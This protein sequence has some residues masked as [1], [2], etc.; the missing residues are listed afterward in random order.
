MVRSLQN[1]IVQSVQQGAWRKVKRLI[2]LLIRSFSARALAVKRV[3][4]NKGKKTAGIDG[5]RWLTPDQK[6]QAIGTIAR[7]QG[8]QPKALKRIR[9]PKKDKSQ[10]RPLS[11]PTMEDRAR[12]ALYMLALAPIA[13]TL[14]DGNSYGFRSKRR[15]ADAID[16]IFKV[17]RLKGSSQW[18]LEAD[19]KGFFDN[20]N[21]DWILQNI[22]INKKIL[23]A[24]LNCG[25]IEDRTFH[26]TTTGVPQG[27]IISPV[28]GNRVLDG[29]E[30]VI[31]NNPRYKRIHGI[32][33]V[34]YA[35]DFIV[36]AKTKE[37]LENEIIPRINAFLAPRGVWLSEKK[38]RITHI[39][40]SFDFLG[41]TIRKYRRSDDSLGKIQ[42]EPSRSSVDSIKQK[43]T[44]TFHQSGQL[45]QD[46]LISRL[47]PVLRG[48]ANYHRHIICGETFAEIDSFVWFRIM[49]WGKRRH[50]AKTAPWLAR[51]YFS[52]EQPWTF[53]DKVSGK[54]L[55]RLTRDIQTFRHIKIQ[56]SANPFDI[57]WKDY[58][59]HRE[60][61]LKMKST[62][63]FLGKL[64]TQQ[65]GF[66]PHCN[67]LIQLEDET[68]FHYTDGDSN[69]R[70]YNNVSMLHKSC[71]SAYQYI[72]SLVKQV[73]PTVS[74]VC[75][76]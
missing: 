75:Y 5:K 22:P 51:T 64:L 66:C 40:E 4:E 49:R 32:N 7:W 26:P 45:T 62:G 30:A 10:T 8:Y 53:Q 9:I 15:C 37:V 41:Q 70:N 67:Q 59:L 39:S 16:Q 60:Q 25:F 63:H 36:T 74:D 56:G 3:T 18:I 54:T 65:N 42:I 2:H 6:M 12:Q 35:D 48:W 17:L 57:Q 28:I 14:A 24:W 58:F 50:P 31:C 21:F 27:G 47:N 33:F 69:N 20:I 55:I 13:E 72:K 71:L 44:E 38:T 19:I 1:R 29:L 23:S 43:I 11:I 34:R 46:E 68:R 52:Q 73:H 76:A 61:S